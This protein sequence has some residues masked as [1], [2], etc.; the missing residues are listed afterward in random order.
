MILVVSTADDR[1]VDI[2][3]REFAVL[4][5]SWIRFNTEQFPQQVQLEIEL[6]QGALHGALHF[7]DYNQTVDLAEITAVWYRRPE[8]PRIH[9]D[10]TDPEARQIAEAEC[11]SA[12]QIGR[13]HV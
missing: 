8:S 13:A 3:G 1:H 12:L 6:K 2:V 11:R 4:G 9:T 5:A 10:V 7:Y